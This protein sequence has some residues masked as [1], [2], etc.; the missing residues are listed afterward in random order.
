M[1]AVQQKQFISLRCKPWSSNNQVSLQHSA[2]SAQP[3]I[4]KQH[5]KQNA[6][7][8]LL[9]FILSPSM[10]NSTVGQHEFNTDVC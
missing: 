1:K 4:N 3:P 5:T 2:W 9:H 6:D 10:F 8:H 7:M